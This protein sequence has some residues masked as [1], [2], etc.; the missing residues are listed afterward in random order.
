MPR[1]T[2]IARAENHA[3]MVHHRFSSRPRQL[4]AHDTGRSKRETT[5]LRISQTCPQSQAKVTRPGPQGTRSET[6]LTEVHT[7]CRLG[8]DVLFAC[9]EAQAWRDLYNQVRTRT[10]AL[11]LTGH[12]WNVK[13]QA[14]KCLP[15]I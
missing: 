4:T 6:A 5:T 8:G 1:A 3:G 10:M 14:H 9:S 12:V 13:E 2:R 15:H 7:E 11:G